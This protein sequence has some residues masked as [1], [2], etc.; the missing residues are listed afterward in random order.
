[1]VYNAAYSFKISHKILSK[2]VTIGKFD[3]T[4]Y[5]L[6]CAT[7]G[8]KVFIHIPGGFKKAG[9]DENYSSDPSAETNVLNV[10]QSIKCLAAGKFDQNSDRDFLFVG[11]Q[12]HLQVY[13][14]Y[15]NADI[16]FH[17]TSEGVDGCC[18]GRVG[19]YP[20][21]LAII[22]AQ[23]TLLGLNK[24]DE[25]QF[26]TITGDSVTAM[27]LCPVLQNGRNQL[28][29][30]SEDY[31]I[32]IFEDDEIVMEMKE[33]AVVSCLT[34]ISGSKFG[35]SLENGTVG[36]YE[37]NTR[38]WRIKSKNMALSLVAFDVNG[39]GQLELVAGWSSGKMDVRDSQSG[40]VV[41]KD[42]LPAACA[43]LV[44]GDYTGSGRQ[45]LVC[46][47]IEGDVRGFVSSE[48]GERVLLT[49][50]SGGQEQV[51]SLTQ[52]KQNME[53]EMKNVE[54]SRQ[55]AAKIKAGEY[56]ASEIGAIPTD[57]EVKV[58]MV[59]RMSDHPEVPSCVQL[60]VRTSNETVIKAVVVFAE[61]IFP[62]ESH[63]AHPGNSGSS[64]DDVV[65]PLR[66]L[67]N[68][69]LDLHMKI[70]VGH[71]TSNYLH[72]FELSKQLPKF[73]MFLRH[74]KSLP[75]DNLPSCYVSF[76]INE[77]INRI[78]MWL[79]MV[80]LL[81]EKPPEDS[82]EM[83]VSFTYLRT[84][85]HLSI[86]CM[87]QRMAA[88]QM[89]VFVGPFSNSV[90]RNSEIARKASD[91]SSCA[92]WKVTFRTDDIELA[93]DLVQSLFEFISVSGDIQC[94]AHFPHVLYN[95]KHLVQ[96]VDD[97]YEAR[98]RLSAEVADNSTL[99]RSMV[100]KAE[101]ARLLGDWKGMRNTYSQLYTTNQGLINSYNIRCQN[102]SDLMAALKLVNQIIQRTANLRVGTE[103]S[104]VIDCG[105]LAIKESKITVFEQ[106]L[107]AK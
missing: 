3:G 42:T 41:F 59:P 58:E 37:K 43:G 21:V 87:P 34:Y 15:N 14:V 23:C 55:T 96:Q 99:I 89:D 18:V 38:L 104:K 67:T 54:M 71:K 26:W 84:G 50:G 94:E 75:A 47:T 64:D 17:Q 6:A 76:V 25:E 20:D 63:V 61:G 1:M 105:R 22:G 93:G 74:E 80:F 98:S 32:R 95:L 39:D 30:G 92:I 70:F 45:E 102:Q 97:L 65:V 48:L 31:D 35:Y 90:N 83:N 16:L 27:I 29:V 10:N 62:G 88:S 19:R 46:C 106:Y 78:F 60:I 57:T 11:T 101:D 66:P 49:G 77:R 51:R 13:D 72:V 2:L 56:V 107:V 53:M 81:E 69:L 68:S 40:E 33:T 91:N 8:G 103:K 28:I 24:T 85:E 100:V 5:A 12:T 86:A 36:V 82:A 52:K 73:S 4:N 9:A 44:V 79:N 7:V